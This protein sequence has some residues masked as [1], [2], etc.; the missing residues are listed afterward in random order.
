M[1][2][3]QKL[4]L[5]SY[6]LTSFMLIFVFKTTCILRSKIDRYRR[7][8]LEKVEH[9]RSISYFVILLVIVKHY[10]NT[11]VIKLTM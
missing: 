3:I 5:N 11:L 1:L 2:F 10:K 9:T 4:T 7:D 8:I 6:E